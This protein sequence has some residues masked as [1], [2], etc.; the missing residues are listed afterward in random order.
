[1]IT[2]RQLL[3]AGAAG[4]A[5]HALAR[6]SRATTARAATLEQLVGYSAHVLVAKPTG[7]VCR[8]EQLGPS[9]RIVT[10]VTVEVLQP[11]D[12]RQTPGGSAIV[13]T[14]GGRMGDIGQLVHGAPNLSIG[15]PAVLFL[16]EEADGVLGVTAMAQGHFPLQ[17]DEKG[18]LRLHASPQVPHLVETRGCAVRK[19]ADRTL[20]DAEAMICEHSLQQQQQ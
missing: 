16:A 19:L 10:Y 7:S 2:R 3:A 8:W 6:P 15:S 11:I 1:M 9:R 20:L 12:G 14:L 17:A 4:L 5:T 13:R 18:D